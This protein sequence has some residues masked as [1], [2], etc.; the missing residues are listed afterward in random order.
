MSFGYWVLGFGG[1]SRDLV[2]TVVD[3]T[4]GTVIGNMTAGGGNAAAF[5]G[6]TV[7]AVAVGA[8]ITGSSSG[9]VG[10]DWGAGVTKV[11][12]GIVMV[13]SSDEGYAD[14]VNFNWKAQGS[15]SGAWAGE[16]VDIYTSGS[17]ADVNGLTIT[18]LTG[19]T[20][21]TA[22]RYHRVLVFNSSTEVRIAELT[23]YEDA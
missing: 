21:T 4:A 10:K 2:Q 8:R 12:S 11:I 15:S 6:T 16:E 9:Y 5:D 23:F 13:G 18:Q 17:V 3:R 22:Y 1:G 14:A 20:T 7:Q 19:F